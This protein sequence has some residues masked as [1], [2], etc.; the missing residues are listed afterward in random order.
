MYAGEHRDRFPEGKRSMDDSYHATWMSF[1]NFDYFTQVAR[2]TT[3]SL[4]CP[5]KKDWIRSSS[6]GWRVGYYVLWGYPTKSDPRPRGANYGNGIWPWDSPIKGSDNSPHT[7]MMADFV[8]K[9]TANP[10]VTS[11]PHGRGGP[12]QSEIGTSPEPGELGS[13]GGNVGLV[14]GSAEWRQQDVMHQ[15]YVRFSASGQPSG[16]IIGYW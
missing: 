13:S 3:N 14:D 1:D 12:V 10:R 11:S 9:G 5:N 8:E 6:V 16:S 15:R 2:V 4:S 7:V